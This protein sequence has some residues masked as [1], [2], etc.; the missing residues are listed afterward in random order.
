MS[1]IVMPLIIF[2]WLT[3][4]S[5]ATE[6]PF[7]SLRTEGG[8]TTMRVSLD[9]TWSLATDPENM[10]RDREWAQKIP[11]E[12]VEAR[13]PWIIQGSFPGYHGLVWYWK[14]FESPQVVEKT[15]RFLLRFEQ[16]DYYAEV[17]MNGMKVGSHEGGETPFVFDVTE[18]IRPGETNRL[19]VRVLNPTDK[20]VDGILLSQTPHRCK[21]LVFVAGG[22]YNHGGVTGSVTLLRVPEVYVEDI[23]VD[24]RVQDG[25]V[26]FQATIHNAGKQPITGT[27]DY[28]ISSGRNGET[29]FATT[30]RNTFPVG[31]SVVELKTWIDRPILWQL[32]DPYLYRGTVRVTADHHSFHEKA[33]RFGFREFRFENGYFH[34]NG[35]RI[36]LRCSHTCNHYPLGQQFPDDPDLLRRDML[37]LKMMGFNMVRFIWGG[38]TPL[39]LDLCD[40]LGLMV[41]NESYASHAIEDSPHFKKRWDDA[42]RKLV[43]RDRNHPSL[44]IWGLLNEIFNNYQFTHAFESIPLFRELDPDCM[45]FLNSGRWDRYR[46]FGIGSVAGLSHWTGLSHWNNKKTS[47]P[48]VGKNVTDHQINVMGISWP[49]HHVAFHPGPNH[50]MAVVRWTAPETGSADVAADFVGLADRRSPATTDVHVFLNGNA[51]FASKLNLEGNGNEVRFEKKLEVKTGDLLDFRVGDGEGF[52][53]SDTTG[54]KLTIRLK[55]KTYDLSPDYSSKENPNGLWS[56]GW[57]MPNQPDDFKLLGEPGI[58]SL[59][60]PGSDRWEDVLHDTHPYQSV[61]H[62]AEIIRSLRTHGAVEPLNGLPVFLSEYGIGSAVDLIRTVRFFEQKSASHLEDA[63]FFK[64]I[65]ERFYADWDAWKLGEVFDRPEDFFASSVGRMASQRTLGLNAIRSNPHLVGHSVTGAIDHVMTGEGLT[66]TFRELKPGTVDAMFD[67]WAPLRWC[68]FAEPFH[69]YRKEPVHLEA[70]LANEDAL[71]PGTYP[72]RLE[73]FGPEG[74]RVFQREF[75]VVISEGADGQWEPFAKS[76]FDEKIP[77][78]LPSGKYRF[79]ATFLYGAAAAGGETYFY[80]TDAAAMPVVEK[81]VVLWGEDGGLKKWL[82]DHGINVRDFDPKKP[83]GMDEI[84]LASKTPPAP[85]GEA[86]FAELKKYIDAGATAIFLCPEIFGVEGNPTAYIPL[87]NK[88]RIET[89]KS[90]LYLTDHWS[91]KHPF[92]EGLPTGGLMDYTCYAEVIPNTIFVGQDDLETAVAGGIK[93]SQDYASGLFLAVH[94]SGQGRFIL[95]SMSIRDQLGKHPAAERILRNMLRWTP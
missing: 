81:T 78:D 43:R 25:S 8:T 51:L 28:A 50:E 61:P 9:G 65:L 6:V 79:V 68:V 60:N 13:V 1:R 37:N 47:E 36:Y 7:N 34:L 59:S 75:N 71:N 24:P 16:V 31:S 22:A 54:I 38:A 20:E 92:F 39:Q 63:R 46:S 40:E 44:V 74:N 12:A 4:S 33:E 15:D 76:W 32:N 53:G 58:G 86:A 91:R 70:I 83:V 42:F 49:G 29:I 41:Y 62:T 14:E 67:A 80:V 56:F 21:R 10:G 27:V 52:Y 85:G 95:N 90:W 93:A 89:V 72:A 2:F 17:W 30:E 88:G 84:I 3:T 87:E 94:R 66:T 73:I 55:G 82:S 26:R 48:W 5:F 35:K 11:S 45:L 23:F 69:V 77:L 64:N 19:A 18:T 57:I